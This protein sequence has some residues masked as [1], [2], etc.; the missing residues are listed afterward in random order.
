M[1]RIICASTYVGKNE[2]MLF[3]WDSSLKTSTVHVTDLCRLISYTA[4]T[5]PE[6]TSS[7]QGKTYNV[8]DEGDTDQGLVN[9]L[10]GDIFNIKT[11]FAGSALSYL[12]SLNLD[13]IV[14]AANSESH[15]VRPYCAR[16]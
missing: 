6:T 3:L 7:F 16:T 13:A 15:W 9:S 12:A 2:K 14:D 4:F 8:S 10:I 1:P 11:G 5:S